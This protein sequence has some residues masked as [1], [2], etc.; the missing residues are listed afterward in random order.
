MLKRV[1]VGDGDG[2]VASSLAAFAKVFALIFL[3]EF[4]FFE[5]LPPFDSTLLSIH[6]MASFA[7]CRFCL[8]LRSIFI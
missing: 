1:I 4:H 5:A 2:L 7:S 8:G 6:D 3:L